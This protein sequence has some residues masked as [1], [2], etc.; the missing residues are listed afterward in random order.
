M[1]APG[2]TLLKALALLKTTGMPVRLIK[3]GGASHPRYRA[4]FQQQVEALGLRDSIVLVGEVA[5]A[6]L[7]LFYSAADV[8]VL[9][10][11]VEGF[12]LPVLEAM[13]CGA[14]VVCST[15]GALAEVVGDAG[16]LV[17]PC[18]AQGFAAAIAS[19]LQDRSLQERLIQGGRERCQL[20]SWGRTAQDTLAVYD[21]LL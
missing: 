18:G 15:A 5:E 10:S 8:F 2:A 11:Y 16:L 21:E 6:H 14:P 9:P 17:E 7:P 4:P 3:V 19:L 20:F 13:A 12:G 1:K